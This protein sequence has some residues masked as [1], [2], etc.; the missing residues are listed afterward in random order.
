MGN[1]DLP[2]LKISKDLF[3]SDTFLT[4]KDAF[5]EICSISVIES[6]SYWICSFND[7]I[8]DMILTMNEFENYLIG[9]S[10]QHDF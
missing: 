3:S 7:C 9:V 4:T 5:K 8:E 10:R 6:E 1:N 2:N